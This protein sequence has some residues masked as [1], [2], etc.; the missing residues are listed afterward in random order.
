MKATIQYAVIAAAGV[1]SRLG[2]GMPKAL[3]EVNGRSII[4]YQLELLKEIPHVRIIVGYRGEAVAEAVQKLRPDIEVIYNRE[5]AATNT[6]QSYYLGT[7]DLDEPFLL[8]DGDIIPQRDSLRAF[9]AQARGETTIGV[10]PVS[11]ED[12]VFVHLDQNHCIQ[13][14]S[15]T[16]KSAYEW[17]NIAIVHPRLLAYENTYVYEQL[18]KFLPLRACVV[19]RLE[20]DTP[21]DIQYAQSV[22]SDPTRGYPW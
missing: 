10:A 17:S 16:E 22:L 15:R 9:L 12:A 1:G 6:L 3:V 5:F 14:F 19:E 8:L 20:I 7:K 21:N 18:E 11:S 13:S 2:R 4:S